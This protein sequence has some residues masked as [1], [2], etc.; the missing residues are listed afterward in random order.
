MITPATGRGRIYGSLKHRSIVALFTDFFD[1]YLSSELCS[2]ILL[3]RRKHRVICCVLTHPDM[4]EL[5]YSPSR[6]LRAATTASVIRESLDNKSLILRELRHAGVD[7]VDTAPEKLNGAV[8]SA[9]IRAR[10]H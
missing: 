9:Y 1:P 8:L 2:Y 10:W 7:I 6:S 4:E 5:G 3:L